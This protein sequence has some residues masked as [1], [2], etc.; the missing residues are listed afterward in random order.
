MANDVVNIKEDASPTKKL[1][2]QSFTR[3]VDTVHQE[4]VTIGDGTNNGRVVA[5]TAANALKVDG[6]AVNQPVT[7]AGGALTVDAIDLDIRNL[8]TGQDKVDARLRNAADAA[9][10][11]PATDR[12][13][14]A[15]PNSVRL[16]DG[17]A[18]YDATKTG[19]LPSAL[20]GG[21]LDDNL[22]AI[23]GTATVTGGVSGTLGVGGTTAHDSVDAANPVKVGHKAIA[24]GANPTAVAA[25]DITHQYANRHGIP[26]VMS[27][28][29]NPFTEES[30]FTAAQTDLAL[31][32]V[33]SGTKIAITR[34]SVT[35]D[36]ANTVNVAYRLG[37]A[38]STL[39]STGTGVAGILSSHPGV[40]AGSGVVEGNGGG[41]LGI[42]ADG[43]DLRFTCGVPTT[44][45]IRVVVTGFTIES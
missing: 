13:T 24:H 31:K 19:Q 22:G 17:A 9:F 21:R 29:M 14:A 42:G 4:E 44:G 28:H 18:F 38:A 16:S 15:G 2:S 25:A 32:T 36:R 39:P 12:T 40:A 11:E 26:F 20:V 45:S 27:G 5:V 33:S 10:I 43:E 7:D 34:V 41:L 3:G 37:F 35:C 1:A 23:G 30:V 6:S 8:A